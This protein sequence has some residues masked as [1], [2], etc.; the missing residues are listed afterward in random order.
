MDVKIIAIVGGCVLLNGRSLPLMT[1]AGN[2]TPDGEQFRIGEPCRAI[3]FATRCYPPCGMEFVDI[4]KAY[5]IISAEEWYDVAKAAELL[6][7]ASTIHYCGRC[8]AQVERSSEISFVCPECGLEQ[9]PRLSPAVMV[10]V[11]RGEEALLVHARN[12]RTRAHGLVAGFVETGETPE[13]CVVREVWEETGLRVG[14]LRYIR[15]QSWPFPYSLMLGFTADWECGELQ[16]RDGELDAGAFYSRRALPEIV[17]PPSLA[18]E[19]I[20]AWKAGEI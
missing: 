12:F 14:N 9:W 19:L 13:Q 11:K 5:G 1:Q 17:T 3:A 15:S 2:V 18:Y 8:G 16:F 10:L 4:R 20:T 6:G 7:W